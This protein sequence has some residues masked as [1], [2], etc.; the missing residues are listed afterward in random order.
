MMCEVPCLWLRFPH[1]AGAI[2][3][4]RAYFGTGTGPIFLDDTQCL[5]ENHTSIV[6]C[7]KSDDAATVGAHNCDHS[8]DVSVICPGMALTIIISKML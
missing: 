8:E 4:G 5:P 3:L 2:A 1:H 6:E 7:F